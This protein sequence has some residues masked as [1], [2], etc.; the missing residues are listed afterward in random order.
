MCSLWLLLLTNPTIPIMN[1]VIRV[2]LSLFSSLSSPPSL[3]KGH[4]LPEN[5][6]LFSPLLLL[7]KTICCFYSRSHSTRWVSVP[8]VCP[9]RARPSHLIG[10][11]LTLAETLLS[12]P[13]ETQ[14]PG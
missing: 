5:K 6:V 13:A 10:L 12:D 1:V 4:F 2:P 11:S 7:P 9:A 8:T 3:L 14:A